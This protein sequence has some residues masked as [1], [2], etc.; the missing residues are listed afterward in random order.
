VGDAAWPVGDAA[1]PIDRTRHVFACVVLLN[2]AMAVAAAAWPGTTTTAIDDAYRPIGDCDQ[3]VQDLI[4]NCQDYVKF[5]GEHGL[6]KCFLTAGWDRDFEL[7]V[8]RGFGTCEK[9]LSGA[10]TLLESHVY[11]SQVLTCPRLVRHYGASAPKVRIDQGSRSLRRHRCYTG[12]GHMG[13]LGAFLWLKRHRESLRR[14]RDGACGGPSLV[15][16]ARHT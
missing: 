16:G 14:R 12:R 15:K 6:Q 7:S 5:V 8:P 13:G 2:I 10:L 4:S 9:D 11:C 1:W 3:G